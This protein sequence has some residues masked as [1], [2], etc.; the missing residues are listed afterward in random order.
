MNTPILRSSD[1]SL[2]YEFQSDASETGIGAVLQQKDGNGTHFVA[3]MSGKL[4]AAGKNHIVHERELL[5]VV[6]S[7]QKRREYLLG[8]IFIVKPDHRPLQYIQTQA[9]SSR[10]QARWVLFLQD[11]HFYWEYVSG[12]SNRAAY[13]LSRQDVD[14]CYTRSTLS[15][16]LLLEYNLL[17]T[18]RITS[19]PLALVGLC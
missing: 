8:N 4:N 17:L 13:A 9:H 1:S 3:Y 5:A 15:Y 12:A 19:Y 2:P 7:L 14:P 16:K 18:Q 11:F 10:H 6:D